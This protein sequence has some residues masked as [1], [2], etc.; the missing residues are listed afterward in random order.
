MLN[1]INSFYPSFVHGFITIV[2]LLLIYSSIPSKVIS[3]SSSHKKKKHAI[4]QLYIL[5]I[6]TTSFIIHGIISIIEWL[7][8]AFS[9][10]LPESEETSFEEQ[11]KYFI[12]TSSVL[13]DIFTQQQQTNTF[14]TNIPNLS[15][16]NN[17]HPIQINTTL[18]Q[19]HEDSIKLNYMIGITTLI[20]TLFISFFSI[21]K[22]IGSIFLHWSPPSYISLLII[23]IFLGGSLLYFY[24]KN[25]KLQIRKLYGQMII[26]L[27]QILHITVSNDQLTDQMMDKLING[28]SIANGHSLS[29]PNHSKLENHSSKQSIQIQFMLYTVLLT[30]FKSM[31]QLL[32]E[33]KPLVHSFNLSSLYE[34]YNVEPISSSITDFQSNID[35][36]KDNKDYHHNMDQL[37]ILIY[38]IY[39]YRRECFMHLLSLEIMTLGHDSARGDYENLLKKVET[40]ML[41]MKDVMVEFSLNMKNILNSKLWMIDDNIDGDH[42]SIKSFNEKNDENRYQT[43]LNHLNSLEKQLRNIQ[44]KI[45]LCRQDGNVLV[46]NNKG[47]NYSFDRIKTRFRHLEQD[48]SQFQIQW[49]DSRNNIND[50]CK[51]ERKLSVESL[52]S[53]PTSPARSI[54]N[55]EV[56]APLSQHLNIPNTN[57]TSRQSWITAAAVA[58]FLES[59][60]LY[61]L[62]AQQTKSISI[63]E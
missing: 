23:Y 19:K 6:H 9:S 15:S 28:N 24:H 51:Y 8:F 38:T 55:D 18:N 45:T 53:P 20:L 61:R 14:S 10:S 49:N 47:S 56:S 2:L 42:Q 33:L 1:W 57:L 11:F 12:V 35:K 48:I 62:Q 3:E 7:N 26:H 17:H 50:I 44:T 54:N 43:L 29:P 34:M 31:N 60:R 59:R 41:E 27:Q 16:N 52:P 4:K 30:Y 21:F 63:S 5:F 40:I 22:F 39:S 37:D 32:C 13:N 36:N 58:S 25:K 46:Q